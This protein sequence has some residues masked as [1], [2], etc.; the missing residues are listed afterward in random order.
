VTEEQK[1][2]NKIAKDKISESNFSAVD[3][4]I[5]EVK[6]CLLKLRKNLDKLK[7]LD[8]DQKKSIKEIKD[9]MDKALL[10]YF[11]DLIEEWE[12]FE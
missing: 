2:A 9:L 10:P 4:N 11:A 5:D 3:D 6:D 1:I 12:N 8:K 7:D